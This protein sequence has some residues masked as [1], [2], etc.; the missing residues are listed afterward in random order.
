MEQNVETNF[1]DFLNVYL[2]FFSIIVYF[3]LTCL[4]HQLFFTTV[5]PQTI[6]SGCILSS[7]RHF[8]SL[9]FDLT[10]N[11]NSKTYFVLNIC[12]KKSTTQLSA[13]VFRL[14]ATVL[15]MSHCAALWTFSFGRI[16]CYF[17]SFH[18]Y[19]V[20]CPPVLPVQAKIDARHYSNST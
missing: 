6:C 7:L 10:E 13:N 4:W 15:K 2:S 19:F 9:Q 17:Q 14:T 5:Q 3:I 12:L 20:R 11:I 8:R 1:L 18:L 16:L